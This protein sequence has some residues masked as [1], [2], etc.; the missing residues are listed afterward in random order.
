MDSNYAYAVFIDGIKE[1]DMTK[2][3]RIVEFNY[4]I[5]KGEVNLMS[6]SEYRRMQEDFTDRIKGGI[7]KQDNLLNMLNLI[8]GKL[9]DEIES[10]SN[11]DDDVERR[12]DYLKSEFE[13]DGILVPDHNT[14]DSINDLANKVFSFQS[15]VRKNQRDENSKSNFN[16]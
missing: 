3:G 14:K 10:M 5:N 9:K 13:Q 7:I 11:I 16:K 2:A 15:H 8:Y 1:S 6:I 12:Y 4:P